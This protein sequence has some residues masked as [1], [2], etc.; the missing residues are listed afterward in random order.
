MVK[1]IIN[2]RDE[3]IDGMK[4]DNSKTIKKITKYVGDYWNCDSMEV[5][6]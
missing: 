3:D 2:L 6:G 5:R 4:I 1:I